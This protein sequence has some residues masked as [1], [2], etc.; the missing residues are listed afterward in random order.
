MNRTNKHSKGEKPDDSKKSTPNLTELLLKCV[1]LPNPMLTMLEWLCDRLMGVVTGH[2]RYDCG[3]GS[4]NFARAFLQRSH[5]SCRQ[6]W[7]LFLF[8]RIL[9]YASIALHQ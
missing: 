7:W 5:H 4:R 8:T 2:F 9:T 1:S 3:H 6:E